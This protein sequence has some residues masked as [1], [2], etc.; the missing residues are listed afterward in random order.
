MLLTFDTEKLMGT[1]L[2]LY[3]YM[4]LV[5]YEKKDNWTA[6]EL[7]GHLPITERTCYAKRKLLVDFGWLVQHGEFFYPSDK[8]KQLIAA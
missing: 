5:M 3:D 2:G 8:S 6:R 1:G 7:C 4:V